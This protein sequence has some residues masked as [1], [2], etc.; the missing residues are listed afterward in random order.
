MLYPHH[1][2]MVL[3]SLVKLVKIFN[4]S[5]M[6]T[7]FYTKAIKC[8]IRKYHIDYKFVVVESKIDSYA[9]LCINYRNECLW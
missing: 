4:L 3:N 1:V 7:C 9:A 8:A 5:F 2:H 6:N